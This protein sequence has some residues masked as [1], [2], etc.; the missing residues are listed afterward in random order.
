MAERQ[1]DGG[2]QGDWRL[3]IGIEKPPLVSE[4]GWV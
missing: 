4:R 1:G 3:E 2:R